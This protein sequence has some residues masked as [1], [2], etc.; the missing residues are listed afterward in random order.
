MRSWYEVLHDGQQ[1][2]A[3]G[4]DATVFASSDGCNCKKLDTPVDR[5]DYLSAAWNGSRQ[6]VAGGSTWWYWWIGTPT[7]ERHVGLSSTD[8]GATWEIF[9]IDG[10]YES[11]GI[12]SSPV[13]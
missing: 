5:F 9:N 3:A 10:Y 2:I 13:K 1:F 12:V 4:S 6:V 7:F 8:G 11:N